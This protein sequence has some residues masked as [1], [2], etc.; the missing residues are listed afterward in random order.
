MHSTLKLDYQRQKLDH[1]DN[2]INKEMAIR[3]MIDYSIDNTLSQSGII[4]SMS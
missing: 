1:K 3:K 2:Q 4:M